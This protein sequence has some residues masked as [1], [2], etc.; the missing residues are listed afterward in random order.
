[1]E[2]YWGLIER[3][4]AGWTVNSSLQNVKITRGTHDG[5]SA[6]DYNLDGSGYITLLDS[7]MTTSKY[8][9]GCIRTM[10]TESFGRIPEDL[11]GSSSGYD[12]D[13]VYRSASAAFVCTLADYSSNYTGLFAFNQG[14]TV[15]S[16]A[17]SGSALSCK[18]SATT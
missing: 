11:T 10:R 5:S 16:Y 4:I 17:Y 18:P 12:C 8:S 1:M 7:Q 14:N 3:Y 9:Y 2:H 15:S 6:T 13:L